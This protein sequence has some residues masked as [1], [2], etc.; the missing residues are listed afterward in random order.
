MITSMI[1]TATTVITGMVVIPALLGEVVGLGLMLTGAVA[2]SLW[3]E[4]VGLVLMLTGA[5]GPSLWGEVVGLVLMLTGAVAVEVA[6]NVACHKMHRM[7]SFSL[8]SNF[9]LIPLNMS[10]LL[11]CIMLV[12]KQAY[13]SHLAKP[14]SL[15]TLL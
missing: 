10:S 2:P 6:H 15:K 3:R 11:I 9:S 14:L 13:K 8:S 1:T 12:F 7:S 5:V 4:V